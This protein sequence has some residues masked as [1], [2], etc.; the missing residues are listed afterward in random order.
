[1]VA[2]ERQQCHI[3][4]VE[5]WRPDCPASIDGSIWRHRTMMYVNLPY[6]YALVSISLV[7]SCMV[8]L[9]SAIDRPSC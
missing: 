5:Q 6:K 3:V 1:M 8:K 2:R 9:T 4:T 7:V